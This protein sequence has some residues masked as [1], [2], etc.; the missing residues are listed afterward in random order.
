MTAKNQAAA[1]R[2][3]ASTVPNVARPQRT[4]DRADEGLVTT[5]EG[6]KDMGGYH[7]DNPA[8]LGGDALRQLANEQGIALS[9]SAQMSDDKVREQLRYIT[10]ARYDA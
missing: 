9:E 1:A 8:L 4:R 2:K 7:R 10:A 6:R 3:T 5:I